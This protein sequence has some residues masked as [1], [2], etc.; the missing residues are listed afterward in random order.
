MVALDGPMPPAPPGLPATGARDESGA[1]H[2]VGGAAPDARAPHRY[3]G[4]TGG[5]QG[6]WRDRG[7][8]EGGE[9][10]EAKSDDKGAKKPG[11]A[12]T[13]RRAEATPNAT[14]LSVGDKEEL[15]LKGLQANVRVDGFRARVVLD[16]YYFNDR[17]QQVEG[18]FKLRLPNEASP[19]LFAFGRT[20]FRAAG[21][22]P[23]FFG[24]DEVVRAGESPEEVMLS[25]KAT[26]SDVK[27]AR[28]VP[29][30]KA[31]HAY[32]ETVRRRVDPALMEWS[33]AGVFSARVFPLAPNSLHRITFG[34]DVDL[35]QAGQDLEY[36]FDVPAA[37][38]VVLDLSVAELGE[39]PVKV[40]P[41]V[42]GQS[43]SGRRHFRFENPRERSVVMRC[44][45]PGPVML[46]GD[47]P[48]T[49]RY[50]AARF[51]PAL[52]QVDLAQAPKAAVFAVDTSLSSAPERM[53]IYLKLMQ[54]ILEAN[55]DSMPS[56]A[57]LFF[58][59]ERHWWTPPVIPGVPQTSAT[60]FVRNHP[61]NVAALMEYAKG[62]ALEGA[63]DVAGALA[64]AAVP[65]LRASR[66]V[67]FDIFLLSDGASTWGEGDANAIAKSLEGFRGSVFAYNTGLAG[68]DTAMLSHLARETGGAVYSVVGEA[69]VAK[70]AT[71]HRM[72]PLTLMGPRL[73]PAGDTADVL[74]A[75]R[76]RTLYPGQ[77]VTMVGRGDPV[78]GAE[79]WLP[80][81]TGAGADVVG[82]AKTRPGHVV[83]SPLAPRV[84][85]QVATAQLEEFDQATEEAAKSYAVHFRVTGKTCSL[86]MLESEAD[87]LRFNIKPEEEA[88]VVKAKRAGEAVA[89]AVAD[90]GASL[91]DPK[92]GFMAWLAKLERMSGAGYEFKAPAS[93]RTAAEMLPAEAY[94]VE[95]GKLA[96][97]SV[98][99]DDIPGAVQE[100]L[101]S[102]ELDYDALTKEAL[103]RFAAHGPAD[104]LKALSS[105]VEQGPGDAVLSR[106][107][108]FSAMEWGLGGEAYHL[109]RR[110]ASSRPYEPQTHHAMAQCLEAMK[111][112][113]LAALHYEI[114]LA[115]KWDPRFGAF[116][117]IAGLDYLRFLERVAK[118]DLASKAKDFAEA[119]LETMRKEFGMGEADLVVVISWNTDATDIDLH[120]KEPTGEECFYSNP[121]T[122]LGGAITQDVT[123]G[124]GP[125]MYVLKKAPQGRYEIRVK[126]Y[127]RDRNRASA[128]TKVYATVFED[129]GRPT[130]RETRKVVTLV[131]G[132]EMQDIAVVKR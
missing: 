12:T 88:F 109:F 19:Y 116:R 121:K 51:T 73:E 75:G 110:V 52:P 89:K 104:A 67:P 32:V 25:R 77:T 33:G 55:R 60:A 91:G 128:R 53:N 74:L 46:V 59:A 3:A 47:D 90:V 118:G 30:E 57:V 14:K 20:S 40:T 44:L 93:L 56:F 86:L 50:F 11:E 24:R 71:A 100:M 108:G 36:V 78:K 112:A 62:L 101:A 80:C 1:M 79:A 113:D 65:P 8:A 34:Y 49:G 28:M 42:E 54:A 81:S 18:T 70:A 29:K 61:E 45:D 76:P 5:R 129:W 125:E 107:V 120:V 123:Q 83:E 95:P 87:Y 38:K 98:V 72:R 85:G 117:Q 58:N 17:A 82:V 69:E 68:T 64:D 6:E 31:V 10:L 132:K 94:R 127:A 41:E 111:L 9:A 131:D 4:P 37:P 115:G 99:L 16:C 124:Y 39:T 27:E 114:A 126:Y 48:K 35:T 21:P 15:E 26:W 130:M 22:E 66:T 63:T 2:P 43:A 92:A 23:Q 13:W 97:K 103:R 122:K 105:L 7:G 102:K 96:A 106:D 84:Y 119:R